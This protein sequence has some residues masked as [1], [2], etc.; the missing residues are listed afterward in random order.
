MNR[1]LLT[2]AFLLG[3]CGTDDP[4]LGTIES[5]LDISAFTLPS[6]D[7]AARAEIVR[8]YDAIDP[9][10]KVPRG[11]LE[12]AL[13]YFD[14]NQ[15]HIPKKRYVVV[16]D[17]S[18]HSGKDRYWL[19]DL[20]SGAVEPHKVSH[21]NGSDPDN[22][23]Y[24]DTFSNVSGSNKTSLGFYLTGEIYDGAHAHSMRL[25]GLSAAGSPNEMANTNARSRYIVVHEAAYVS[26][27]NTGQQGRSNGCPALD[28]DI[29]VDMVD[30]IHG[31]SLMYIATKPL[32]A[33]VG[34]AT[35]GDSLCDGTEDP[36]SCDVDC[37]G[38]DYGG[39]PVG[40]PGTDE[41]PDAATAG[42]SAG[43]GGAGFALVLAVAGLRRRRR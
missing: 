3:A 43:G 34:R 6:T 7:A 19:V 10:N 14:A 4:E 28:P 24:A 33:P 21:G 26:D 17:M 13:L 8:R 20:Q 39:G 23:G 35:C 16:I 11:L 38:P 2:T 40:E 27:T 36:T 25:D 9:T 22:N 18:L 29:E 1:A 12:D 37:A 5:E 15:T 41:D 30:R 31:G 32:A 42:C